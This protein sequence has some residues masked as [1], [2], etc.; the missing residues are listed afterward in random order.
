M[1]RRH[2]GLQPGPTNGSHVRVWGFLLELLV[3]VGP[4]QLS[5]RLAL[6]QHDADEFADRAVLPTE[7]IHEALRQLGRHGLLAIDKRGIVRANLPALQDH[8]RHE[9]QVEQALA[10]QGRRDPWVTPALHYFRSRCLH[11]REPWMS[12]L[13]KA[14]EHD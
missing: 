5:P 1:R 4:L 9:R 12:E 14:I 6:M 3:A 11:V 13:L 7:T 8:L 2:Q 10:L